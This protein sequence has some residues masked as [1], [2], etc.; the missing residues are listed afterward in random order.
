MYQCPQL[1]AVAGECAHMRPGSELGPA[2]GF[3][4]FAEQTQ[5]T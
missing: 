3:S 5:V 4:L 2:P 1:D